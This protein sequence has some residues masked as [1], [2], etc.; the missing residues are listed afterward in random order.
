MIMKTNKLIITLSA[1]LVAAFVAGCGES[2]PTSDEKASGVN[3]T[4]TGSKTTLPDAADQ[5]VESAKAS[6][7]IVVQETKTVLTNATAHIEQTTTAITVEA[8]KAA[9]D[10]TAVA[11]NVTKQVESAAATAEAKA[12]TL[13]DKAKALVTDKK[14][15]EA[16]TSLQQLT[17]MQLTA[18]Q[19]KMVDDLK[20]TI[21]SA[22]G[23][24]PAKSVEG[25]FKK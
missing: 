13:I 5:A 8:K 16:L 11:T 2:K 10:A 14:Y 1:V 21:T 9:E 12:Q 18:D 19:Q 20:A 15:Q 22:L 17:G 24:D 4:A 7:A 6:A 3:S 23:S 25:L